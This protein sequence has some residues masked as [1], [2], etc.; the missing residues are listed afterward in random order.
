MFEIIWNDVDDLP[1]LLALDAL[2]DYYEYDNMFAL[3]KL[4]FLLIMNSWRMNLKICSLIDNIGD[5]FAK[6]HFKAI[7]EPFIL[8]FLISN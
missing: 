7:V 4:K 5:K 8:K 1:K 6:N 3:K 2:I